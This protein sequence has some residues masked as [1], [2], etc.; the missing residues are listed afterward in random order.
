MTKAQIQRALKVNEALKKAMVLK[1]G[2]KRDGET[3]R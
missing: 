1:L 3:D 2:V